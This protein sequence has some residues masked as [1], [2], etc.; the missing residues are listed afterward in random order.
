MPLV[1]DAVD[2]ADSGLGALD[3]DLEDGLQ[4][5]G[6]RGQLASVEDTP[7]GGHDLTGTPMDGVSVEGD[8]VDVESAASHV[9]VGEDTLFG[10]PLEATDNGV[11]DLIEVLDTLGD[12]ADHVGAGNI[13][14]K[15]PDLPGL[16][17]VHLEL[18]GEVLGSLLSLLLVADLAVLDLISQA[19]GKGVT[20]HEE[21]VVLVGRLGEAHP[22][23]LFGDGFPVGDDGV[24]LFDGDAGVVFFE[25]FEADFEMELAG[26]GD[27]V[28]AGL[29]GLDQDHG[30]GLGEPLETLDQLGEI[31]GVLGLDSDLDD[32]GDGELHD[33]HVVGLIVGGDGTSLNKV[34]IN[35][36]QTDNVTARNILNLLN[37][38]SH[39]QDRSQV[40]DHG[41]QLCPR[42]QDRSL[43][44]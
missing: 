14:A 12:L 9:L 4:D 38:P 18:L 34:L 30:V 6:L 43:R 10:G 32:W 40:Q 31:S 2:T 36:D 11:L 41:T 42:L 8:I 39:R 22:V 27:D 3:L 37:K 26:T 44:Q 28:L 13:G 35:T 1:E 23:G 25:I 19:V 29:A 33:L 17:R 21:P 7:G 20:L 5:A 16:I 15:A 24:G